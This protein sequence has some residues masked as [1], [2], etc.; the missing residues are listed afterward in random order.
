MEILCYLKPT[1]F[2]NIG[3]DHCFLTEESRAD[4]TRMDESTLRHTGEMLAQMSEARGK[5]VH[6]LWHGGEPMVLPADYYWWAAEIL[7]E[8]LPDH[9]ESMQ[10]SLIPY[11]DKYA[12]FVRERLGNEIG[13]SMDFSQRHVKGSSLNYR[14]L[15]MGKVKQA[16]NNGH[17]VVPGMVPGKNQLGQGG[18]IVD[19][20]V[21]CGFDV[22]NVERYNCF[23]GE[24][25]TDWPSNAEHSQFLINLFD[26][27][28][29]RFA[30]GRKV[31][32]INVLQAGLNG[33]MY[34]LP[35]DRWGGCCQSDFVT[36]EPNGDLNNCPDKATYE[37]AY[38]NVRD[39]YTGFARSPSRRRWIRIQAVDHKRDHCETCENN[40][41]CQSGC[42]ITPNGPADG[43]SECSGY[44]TFL[45]HVRNFLSSAHG[46]E[47]CQDYLALDPFQQSRWATL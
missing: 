10:T 41:W 47:L 2:C 39:G 40:A 28:M 37:K 30:R 1:N 33:V 18:S 32:A 31:P 35:G 19:W 14:K 8:Y 38:A 42:P 36:V 6:I 13:T 12:S 46:R 15:W 29:Q 4:K 45:T 7:D 24:A 3:C 25:P 27:V 44:R 20:F 21:E 22:F 34:G 17:L 43:E 9:Y 23:G 11:S 16:R 26:A 5:P